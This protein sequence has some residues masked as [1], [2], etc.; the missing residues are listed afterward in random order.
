MVMCLEYCQEILL[1]DFIQHPLPYHIHMS[2][3]HLLFSLAYNNCTS[4]PHSKQIFSPPTSE[5]KHQW[6]ESPLTFHWQTSTSTTDWSPKPSF[7]SSLLLGPNYLPY[8]GSYPLPSFQ[9]APPFKYP[10]SCVCTPSLQT[11][12]ALQH[13]PMRN[14][15]VL[16]PP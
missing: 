3:S 10:F 13:F 16:L 7:C 11:S 1:Q 8:S 14:M 2:F 12:L 4:P 15:Q 5:Q 9:K 6:S